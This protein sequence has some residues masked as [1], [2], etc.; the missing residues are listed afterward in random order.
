M[1]ESHPTANTS[2]RSRT[3]GASRTPRSPRAARHRTATVLTATLSALLLVP[4]TPAALAFPT[5]HLTEDDDRN[6]AGPR[7]EGTPHPGSPGTADAPGRGTNVAGRLVDGHTDHAARHRMDTETTAGTGSRTTPVTDTGT[8][9]AK[10][11]GFTGFA[12]RSPERKTAGS[13]DNPRR[14]GTSGKAEKAGSADGRESA[15]ERFGTGTPGF[16]KTPWEKGSRAA[17]G[18]RERPS[19]ATLDGVPAHEVADRAQEQMESLSS[20]RLRITAPAYDLRMSVDEG[21]DCAGSVALRGKGRLDIV[22]RGDAVWLKP[23]A[24]FWKKDLGGARGAEAA[25]RFA[26]RYIRGSA[27][28]S[29]LQG[30]TGT[31]DLDALRGGTGAGDQSGRDA[32]RAPGWKLGERTDYR[33]EPTVTVRRTESGARVEMVVAA[34]GKP[35]PLRVVREEADSGGQRGPGSGGE[36]SRSELRLSAFD[37]PVRPQ[38]PDRSRTIPPEELNEH[39]GKPSEEGGEPGEPP[40]ERVHATGRH[41]L[42]RTPGDTGTVPTTD[43]ADGRAPTTAVTIP[44]T[45]RP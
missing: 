17:E 5:A 16:P 18:D 2:H 26:G 35:Y 4:A 6:S 24:A 42:G 8:E 41:P 19:G 11:T 44:T 38:A 31:C 1:P 9:N 10:S 14:S 22:K 43:P 13:A 23:D 45:H 25:E 29:A 34:E 39:L 30:I 27:Q 20:V 21:G 3:P 37:E 28:D 15:A 12:D 32:P 40:T 36:E 7:K 33:G